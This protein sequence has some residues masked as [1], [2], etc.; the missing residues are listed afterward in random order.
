M[1]GT[2]DLAITDVGV[3]GAGVTSPAV[4]L[5]AAQIFGDGVTINSAA[6]SGTAAQAGTFVTGAGASFGSDIISFTEGAIFSTGSAASVQ[7]PNNASDYSE[8][9]AGIDGDGDFDELAGNNTF[10]ASFLEVTFTPDV[11][12]GASAGDVGRMTIQIVFGSDEY[13]EFVYGNVNDTLAVIVNGANQATVP[14][15]L[16]VGIDTINDAATF[17]PGFGSPTFD[18]NPEHTSAGFESAN[19]SLYVNNENSAFN[20]QMDGFTITIPVT[21]DVI[22]GQQNTIKIGIADT[23][24]PGWD[25]WMFVKADSGQTVLVAEQDNFNTPTNVPQTIDVTANDHD[26]QGDTLTVTHILGE[27]VGVGSVVTLASGVTVT[28]GADGNLT[29]EGDGVNPANDAFTYEVTDGNG[30]SAVTF[31][32]ITIT[33]AVNFAPDAV[34][35]A[36]AAT[37]DASLNGN[38]FSDN[39]SGADSDPEGDAFT[40]TQVN[41]VAANVGTQITLASGAL[42]TVNP[43]GSYDYDPNMQF[44][45]L[46]AGATANDSFTYQISDGNGGFDTATVTIT[47][48]GINDAPI[49]QDDTEITTEDTI[50]NDSVLADNG[51]SQ[52]SDAENDA[53][54]VTRVN[55]IVTNVGNQ[56]MLPSGALLTVNSNGTYSYNPNGQFESLAAGETANDSFTYEVSDGNGGFDTATVNVTIDGVNDQPIAQD[57]ITSIDEN[58]VLSANV[59]VDNGNGP[60]ADADGSD[61]LTI[62]QVNGVAGNVDTQITLAS[63]ALLTVNSDGTYSYDPNGQ[64]EGLAAGQTGADSFTYQI[65]DGNG[66]FDTATVNIAVDGVNDAPQVVDPDNPNTAPADPNAIV[67]LQ[68]GEDGSSITPLDISEFFADPDDAILTFT[69][70]AGAPP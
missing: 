53:L 51:N 48:D 7:A 5:L 32:N 57:D 70:G 1:A 24:D 30:S 49:A 14:N 22:V 45:N 64:F 33:D 13:N 28:V 52:D 35:D 16:A 8:N 68:Q 60:D 26:L 55:G 56:I 15:G 37:E 63:G 3:S 66:G 23:G 10:D 25:S 11:P 40:V 17:N 19:P 54:T 2:L 9:P 47:I 6:Y 46:A 59:L 21:F 18:P 69:L 31:A 4:D 27:P 36:L 29:V 50:L 41:G 39:G 44:D 42:L 67:P 34:D 58:S 61:I 62:S 43:D 20:T 38:L 12:P 65:S